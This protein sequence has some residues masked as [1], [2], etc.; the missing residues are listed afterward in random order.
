MAQHSLKTLSNALME[1][2]HSRKYA[3]EEAAKDIQE[4]NADH[5]IGEYSQQCSVC[6]HW[7]T[8]LDWKYHYHA[9]E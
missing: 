4:M 7:L 1:K 8:D 2:G 5:D 9:C 3:E 6:R